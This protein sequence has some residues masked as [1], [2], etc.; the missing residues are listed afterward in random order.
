MAETSVLITSNLELNGIEVMEWQGMEKMKE[1]KGM[2]RMKEVWL[3]VST[4][5][6]TGILEV[7][8]LHALGDGGKEW[9]K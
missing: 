7:A 5:H 2:E 9:M 1:W 4:G 8:T 3:N 6:P